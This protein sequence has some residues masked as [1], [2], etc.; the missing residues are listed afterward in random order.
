MSLSSQLVMD[1]LTVRDLRRDWKPIRERLSRASTPD[2]QHP[3]P[4]RMHRA[5]SWIQ[6]IE[7]LDDE[8]HLDQ[9]IVFRWISLNALYGKWD[10]RLNEPVR[11]ADSLRE[12]CSKV[13]RCDRSQSVAAVLKFEEE[14]VLAILGDK[15][16]N[17]SFWRCAQASKSFRIDR[18]YLQGKTWYAQEKWD[19]LLENVLSRIYLV[20]C[21]LVHGAS[22]YA[23]SKNRDMLLRCD[24]VLNQLLLAFLLVIIEQAWQEDWGELCYP[25]MDE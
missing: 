19:M 12:F 14:N 25:P 20:R 9:R 1:R 21:Q 23:S 22:T 13:L 16:T 24:H 8:T 5:F 2:K 17:R 4:I 6:A 10:D 11:D 7:S 15:F 18:T 3:L